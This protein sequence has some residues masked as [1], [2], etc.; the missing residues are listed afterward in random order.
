MIFI[1]ASLAFFLLGSFIRCARLSAV[2]GFIFSSI[3]IISEVVYPLGASMKYYSNSIIVVD[4]L[5]YW[6]ALMRIVIIIFSTQAAFQDFNH[7]R[8]NFLKLI[9]VIN[10]LL[11][12]SFISSSNLFFLF[13]IFEISIIPIF[14]IILSWG[15]QPEKVKAAYALFFFTAI[16]ASP[17]VIILTYINYLGLGVLNLVAESFVKSR[18]YGEV[19]TCLIICGFIVKLPIYGL[20]LWLPLAHVEAPVYGSIILAGILLKLGGVGL[21]RLCSFIV[22]KYTANLII[23]ICLISILLVGITCMYLTDLKKIIAF[24]SVSHIALSI[25]FLVRLNK[26]RLFSVTLMIIVHAFRSS[27]MFILVYLFY[28]SSNSRNILINMGGLC[29]Y[30]YLR[31]MWLIVIISRIGGPPS[32]NLIAE[33]LGL[34]YRFSLFYKFFFLAVGGFIFSRAYHFILYR[35][36]IQ[37]NSSW[38]KIVFN[39]MSINPSYIIVGLFHVVYRVTFVLLVRTFI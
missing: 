5:Q 22:S 36:V 4:Y 20:H 3:L 2:F 15:Y 23:L 28:L 12:V 6:M 39:M 9:I 17:I 19:V 13:I 8:S 31:F 21:V 29:Q 11:V 38:D 33:I 37:R 24:S 7:T 18:F 26:F 1:C 16:S 32:I 10:T 30:P 35:T 14:S 34:L 25:L 27:G